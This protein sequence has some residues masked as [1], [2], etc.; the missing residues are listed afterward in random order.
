MQCQQS[1]HISG[2]GRIQDYDPGLTLYCEK[3][4]LSVDLYAQPQGCIGVLDSDT[5]LRLG[6][7]A[8]EAYQSPL[9]CW[10]PEGRSSDYFIDAA[11]IRKRGGTKA[12]GSTVPPRLGVAASETYQSK[13]LCCIPESE[14]SNFSSQPQG[15]IGLKGSY[16][17]P[18]LA[19]PIRWLMLSTL[20]G[21][22]KPLDLRLP[23]LAVI[24]DKCSDMPP[25]LRVPSHWLPLLGLGYTRALD[26]NTSVRLGVTINWTKR[27]R[28]QGITVFN[29]FSFLFSMYIFLS[30]IYFVNI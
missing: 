7:E 13:G 29:T 27:I 22:A 15:Y 21:T 5:P 16:E 11:S 20:G 14:T 28:V 19:V 17:A 25:R 6:A 8:L 26:S 30:M 1:C 18:S 12:L 10:D 23:T 2:A 24:T 3:A 4:N 9:I